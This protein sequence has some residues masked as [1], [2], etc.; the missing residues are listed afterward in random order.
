MNHD[1]NGLIAVIGALPAWFIA[2]FVD[3][4]KLAIA[5]SILLPITF[6]FIGKAVDVILKLYLERRRK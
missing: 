5:T 2:A 4:S 6:F 3:A 1:N